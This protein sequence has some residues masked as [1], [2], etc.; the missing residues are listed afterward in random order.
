M[1]T[2]L[3]LLIPAF[4]VGCTSDG[5]FDAVG[6]G[7]AVSSV[8]SAYQSTQQPSIIGYDAYG[9]PIYR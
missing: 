6:F 2:A 1:K 9:Q 5:S 4:L 7:K 3:I 8:S